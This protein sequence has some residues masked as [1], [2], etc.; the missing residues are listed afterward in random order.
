[1]QATLSLHPPKTLIV[2]KRYLRR[3]EAKSGQVSAFLS[4]VLLSYCACPAFI[5]VWDGE[6]RKLHCLREEI[7]SLETIDQD[8]RFRILPSIAANAT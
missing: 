7:F 6:G 8:R 4:V 3:E 5:V 2:G 1:M